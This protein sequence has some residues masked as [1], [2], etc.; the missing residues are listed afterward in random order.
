MLPAVPDVELGLELGLESE[1]ELE[2]LDAPPDEVDLPE[3][4]PPL[5]LYR[6]LYQP[7]PFRWN[8]DREMS[9]SSV[10]PHSSHAVFGASLMLC[11]YSLTSLHFW[12]W[13]S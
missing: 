8:A 11:Q 3:E 13:Y 9:R 7:P 2:P 6:S 4:F 1:L 10:P 12:H 5:E